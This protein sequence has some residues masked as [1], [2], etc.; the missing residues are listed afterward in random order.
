MCSVK[1]NAKS[2]VKVEVLFM[3]ASFTRRR[4]GK[5]HR[6]DGNQD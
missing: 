2:A 4:E 3:E 5:L 1:L 6:T